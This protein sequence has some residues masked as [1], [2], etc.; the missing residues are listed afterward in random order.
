MRRV[1]I[2]GRLQM[3]RPETWETLMKRSVALLAAMPVAAIAGAQMP[4]LDDLVKG[5]Q[6]L[7]KAPAAGADAGATDE[8]TGA[9][10]IK[11]SMNRAAEAAA[12]LA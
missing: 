1:G 11:L 5:A 4:T 9:A 12:P 2:R 7:P 10:G 8:K 6:K 3:R